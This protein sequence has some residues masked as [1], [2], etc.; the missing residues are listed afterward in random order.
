MFLTDSLLDGWTLNCLNL[1]LALN[2]LAQAESVELT[3]PVQLAQRVHSL[4]VSKPVKPVQ[5]SSFK[6]S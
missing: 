6:K 5:G 1:C 3:Q 4:Q 2:H